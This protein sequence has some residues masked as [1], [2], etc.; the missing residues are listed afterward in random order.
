MADKLKNLLAGQVDTETEP[1][2]RKQLKDFMP[3]Q[4]LQIDKDFQEIYLKMMSLF[5]TPGEIKLIQD[6]LDFLSDKVGEKGRRA[7]KFVISYFA[8]A[9][10][11]VADNIDSN[12]VSAVQPFYCKAGYRYIGA[13]EDIHAITY[14]NI[15]TALFPNDIEALKQE[16]I[17]TPSIRAK[18]N[19][20][21]RWMSADVTFDERVIAF[22]CVEALMFSSSFAII[23]WFKTKSLLPGTLQANELIFRDEGYH[24]EF[25]VLIHKY[26]N[27]KTSADRI[28]KIIKEAV[29]IEIQFVNA[30][31]P[32]PIQDLNSDRVSQY[33]KYMA[34]RL[35]TQLQIPKIYNVE[36]S[37]MYMVQLGIEIKTSFFEMNATAYMTPSTVDKSLTIVDKF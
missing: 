34:D 19:F 23:F 37:C 31:L 20:M 35:A 25:G 7:L 26:I 8:N 1:L 29:E 9:D 33:V 6:I 3:S 17:N 32:E 15:M 4:A 11:I 14:E 12:L 21:A 27:N 10:S 5:W 30:A 28:T 2:L 22:L 16:I 13:C 36:N 24:Q 18:I